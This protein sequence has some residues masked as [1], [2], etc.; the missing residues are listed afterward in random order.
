MQPD[1]GEQ[2]ALQHVQR[3]GHA[4]GQQLGPHGE[5]HAALDVGVDAEDPPDEG[6]EDEGGGELAR[7]R[8]G[9][10]VEGEAEVV[11][12]V[13]VVEG[14]VRV[15]VLVGAEVQRQDAAEEGEHAH[16]L[17]QEPDEDVARADLLVR[18]VR[19]AREPQH[20]ERAVVRLRHGQRRE[21]DEE[22][23]REALQPDELGG[24]AE[25]RV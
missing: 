12:L 22:A 20:R 5:V 7:P 18:R 17:G 3:D 15:H 25:A 10:R 11:Q 4:R 21:D 13:R 2:H 24:R 8:D 16:V 14:E 1:D 23:R 6:A 9:R 19:L